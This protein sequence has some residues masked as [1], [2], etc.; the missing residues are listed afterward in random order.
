MVSI[1]LPKGFF[2]GISKEDIYKN[3]V[4]FSDKDKI[5][6]VTPILEKDSIGVHIPE[7]FIEDHSVTINSVFIKDVEEID[8]PNLFC[9]FFNSSNRCSYKSIATI[10]PLF[11]KISPI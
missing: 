7:E 2:L 4:I 1:E 10:L 8:K 3:K 5:V 9:A 11:F 6:E